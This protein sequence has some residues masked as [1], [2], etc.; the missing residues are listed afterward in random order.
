[1]RTKYTQK[2]NNWPGGW[3]ASN[4]VVTLCQHN[5][6]E[7]S[8]VGIIGT[9][10]WAEW[11]KDTDPLCFKPELAATPPI[12][13]P[14]SSPASSPISSSINSATI[15][16]TSS[17]TSSSSQINSPIT[18]SSPKSSAETTQMILFFA[19]LFIICSCCGFLLVLVKN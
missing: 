4:D 18:K 8:K 6:P 14:A 16:P 3:V 11:I 5:A 17:P 9:E 19:F 13:S 7:N 1:M 15:S 10:V 12:S 2:C